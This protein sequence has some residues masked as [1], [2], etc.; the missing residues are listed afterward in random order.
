MVF[1]MFR[2][3]SS[4]GAIAASL[5]FS[6]AFYEQYF[7]WRHCFN[8]LGRCYDSGSGVVYLEQSG[9]IWASLAL[10]SALIGGFLI[11]RKAR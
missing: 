1:R 6:A 9:A 10:I 7:K 2:Y 11:L 3:V 4:G 5:L 8:E